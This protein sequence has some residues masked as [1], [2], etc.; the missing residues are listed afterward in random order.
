MQ[1]CCQRQKQHLHHTLPEQ[2]YLMLFS[3]LLFVIL[4]KHVATIKKT[5]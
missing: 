4:G 1:R 2:G 3:K 5:N